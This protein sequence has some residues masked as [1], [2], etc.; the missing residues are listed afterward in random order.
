MENT[1][2][3]ILQYLKKELTMLDLLNMYYEIGK[4][5]D[6]QKIDILDLEI[7]LKSLFGIVI[8]FTRRNLKNMVKLYKKYDKS[9]LTKLQQ[10]KW[11]QIIEILNNKKINDYTKDESLLELKNLKNMI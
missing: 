11:I 1:K 6:E 4:Y 7:Y 3:I 8:S 5:I 10:Y 9:E 2:T